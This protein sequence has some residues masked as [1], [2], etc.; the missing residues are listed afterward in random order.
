[1]NCQT[2]KDPLIV[3]MLTLAEL[4]NLGFQLAADKR[5][6]NNMLKRGTVTF[7]DTKNPTRSCRGKS[8]YVMYSFNSNT[9]HVD[10]INP[11]CFIRSHALNKQKYITRPSRLK[12]WE[13]IRK[14]V[15]YDFATDKDV[16]INDLVVKYLPRMLNY[17]TRKN[18]NK[19]GN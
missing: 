15:G 9:G 3:S 1:M 6:I 17:G 11:S 18:S 2:Q 16:A 13:M 14:W 10:R 19:K 8:G 7:I 4:A 12:S 5:H